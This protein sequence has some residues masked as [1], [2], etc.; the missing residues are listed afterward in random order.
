MSRQS[1]DANS[2]SGQNSVSSSSILRGNN[3]S[4]PKR[5]SSPLLSKDDIYAPVSVYANPHSTGEIIRRNFSRKHKEANVSELL[6]SISHEYI[7]RGIRVSTL[8]SKAGPL[9]PAGE[10]PLQAKRHIEPYISGRSLILVGNSHA[11]SSNESSAKSRKRNTLDSP[12]ALV[13]NQMSRRKRKAIRHTLNEQRQKKE[14]ATVGGA[15]NIENNLSSAAI[16]MLHHNWCNYFEQFQRL[17]QSRQHQ[18]NVTLDSMIDSGL[19]E[20]RGAKVQVTTCSQ[21]PHLIGRTGIVVNETQETWRIHVL[22]NTRN[23]SSRATGT[24]PLPK[25]TERS[26]DV[27]VN[28]SYT[29]GKKDAIVRDNDNLHDESRTKRN[30]SKAKNKKKTNHKKSDKILVLV[31]KKGSTLA[32]AFAASDE[33]GGNV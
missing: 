31:P 9:F 25:S 8:K 6:Q 15:H 23:P 19:L 29:K 3:I 28:S 22:P 12:A 13:V 27:D 11:S 2:N 17:Q 4:M 24:H 10:K 30:N 21:H 1:D 26:S 14:T 16:E 18:H 20:M 5:S 7:L 32:I 33:G